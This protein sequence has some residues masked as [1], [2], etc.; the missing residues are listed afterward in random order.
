MQKVEQNNVCQFSI[1]LNPL[2]LLLRILRGK[3][4]SLNMTE[5]PT[6]RGFVARVQAKSATDSESLSY[7]EQKYLEAMDR[8]AKK[9]SE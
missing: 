3:T 4:Q 5:E 7:P 2:S 1:L 9:E 6:L 8:V